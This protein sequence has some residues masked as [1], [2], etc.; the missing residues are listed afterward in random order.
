MDLA[1]GHSGSN[2]DALAASRRD[3]LGPKADLPSR[4][5]ESDLRIRPLIDATLGSGR[6]QR[7]RRIRAR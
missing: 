6:R 2:A 1:S 4:R 3:W 7:S 5:I